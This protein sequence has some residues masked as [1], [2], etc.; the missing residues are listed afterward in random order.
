MNLGPL[1]SLT[2]LALAISA[3]LADVE[4]P[5]HKGVTTIARRVGLE[6]TTNLFVMARS[7]LELVEHCSMKDHWL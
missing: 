1:Q 5:L 6:R 3:S 7:D 4:E 2:V